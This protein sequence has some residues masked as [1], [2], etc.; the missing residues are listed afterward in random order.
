MLV[1][2]DTDILPF[3]SFWMH[4]KE[5]MKVKQSLGT[6]TLFG[7]NPTNREATIDTEGQTERQLSLKIGGIE[8]PIEY[9]SKADK[10]VT[11]DRVIVDDKTTKK[12][13]HYKQGM[14][15]MMIDVN[16]RRIYEKLY[17]G[18]G[19]IYVSGDFALANDVKSAVVSIFQRYGYMTENRAVSAV[20]SL[21]KNGRYHEEIFGN[22]VGALNTHLVPGHLV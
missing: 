17:H 20:E 1:A 9:L 6:A 8:V 4:R 22:T 15:Q 5:L 3:K 11:P 14:K 21:I 13:F 7:G 16:A 12:I 18:P 19:H 10:Y 2:P